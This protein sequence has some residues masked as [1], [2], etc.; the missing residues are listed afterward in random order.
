MAE[1]LGGWFKHKWNA[2]TSRDPTKYQ[3]PMSTGTITSYRPDRVTMS[4]TSDRTIVGSL[5]NRLAMDVASL[6]YVHAR[7]NKDGQFQET[8]DSGIHY[9]LNDEA[10]IDQTGMALIQDAM[11]RLFEE[12][13][14]A[15]IP[16]NTTLNPIET[17]GFDVKTLRVGVVKSW[18]PEQVEVRVYNDHDGEKYDIWLPKKMVA[19]VQNPLYEVMNEEN[20]SL[21]RLIRKLQLLDSVD[22]ASSSGKLDIIVQLPY[23]I[24]SEKRR[25]EAE[26]R[27]KSIEG[28]LSGSKYGVAYTDGT[29]KVIQLNRPAENNL[30]SQIEYLWD[31][32]YSEIGLTTKVFNGTADEAEMKNYYS[33]T[34]DP[35]ADAIVGEMNRKFLSKTARSQRQKL[36]YFRDIFKLA[37]LETLA[38]AMDSL[39]R[40]EIMSP[41][42]G[43]AILG[44]RPSPNPDAK[45]PKNRNLNDDSDAK[46]SAK[47]ETDAKD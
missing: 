16:V 38:S 44:W 30:L 43:R 17:G 9:C 41:D 37:T 25:Q 8:I 13:C 40:N 10:N 20:S 2:L 39:S 19:I 34:I 18:S 6:E 5:Y 3:P 46:I 27:I 32:V 45:I 14:V 1:T 28:Q 36:M 26:N 23:V 24:R 7:V 21:Q 29:E 12:G 4:I 42:D 47:G 31:I 11:M 15:I 35:L 33:R 22:E